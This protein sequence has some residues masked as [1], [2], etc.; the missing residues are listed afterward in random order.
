MPKINVK[1]QH[2][3]KQVQWHSESLTILQFSPFS[4]TSLRSN[5]YHKWVRVAI[6]HRRNKNNVM[7]PIQNNYWTHPNSL[8][9]FITLLLIVTRMSDYRQVSDWRSNLRDSSI[10]RTI[11]L[12]NSLLHRLVSS[13]VSLLVVVRKQLPTASASISLSTRMVPCLSSQL[14][15]VTARNNWIAAVL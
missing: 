8:I 11:K 2:N 10:Q 1:T 7:W 6:S 3:T 15:I 5:V 14:L 12:Y 9:P 13:M 4:Y